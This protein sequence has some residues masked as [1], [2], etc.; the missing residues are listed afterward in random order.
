MRSRAFPAFPWRSRRYH[1]SV[2]RGFTLVEL[3]I[4]MAIVG[5]VLSVAMMGYRH[6]RVSG[7]EAA[8]I[9]ALQTINQAQFAYMQTCGHQRYAPTLVSLGVPP[10]GGDTAF[11][12]PDL[13][14]S[15]PLPKSGYLLQ[16]AGTPATEILEPAGTMPE[17]CNGAIPIPAYRLTADPLNPG[18]T[19]RR[20]F[21]TNADRVIYADT[22]T[23]AD[24]MPET[25]AP[26]HG[27]EVK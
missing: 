2:S 21:G 4:V 26:A 23:Y 18:V 8:A 5:V 10:S 22:A 15:D 3:L 13:T 24:N 25:G 16:M 27:A 6:A 1:L 11:L 17:S 7:A 9:S 19:G 14:R 12:S 20:Y